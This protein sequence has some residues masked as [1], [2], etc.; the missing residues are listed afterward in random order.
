M[1]KKQRKKEEKSIN[2]RSGGKQKRA[3]FQP[4]PSTCQHKNSPSIHHSTTPRWGKEQ[5][6]SVENK[7]GLCEAYHES[8]DG[9]EKKRKKKDPSIKGVRLIKLVKGGI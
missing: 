3:R 8:V 4:S 7:M 9:E 5:K 6:V 2:S 1:Y